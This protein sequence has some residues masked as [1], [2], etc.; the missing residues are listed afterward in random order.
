MVSF[1]L[2]ANVMFAENAIVEE[3]INKN[4][5]NLRNWAKGCFKNLASKVCPQIID[6]NEAD[7][8]KCIFES[9]VEDFTSNQTNMNYIK[10]YFGR[11]LN[12][13]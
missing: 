5:N 4:S 1:L 6:F 2:L 11:I 10:G 9:Y 3:A 12:R 7:L 13:K 8:Y